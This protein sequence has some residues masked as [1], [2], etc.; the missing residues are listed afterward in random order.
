VGFDNRPYNVATAG[1]NYP[2]NMSRWT[3]SVWN[4]VSYNELSNTMAL[5][6][7]SSTATNSDVSLNI[8]DSGGNTFLSFLHQQFL[9]GSGTAARPTFSSPSNPQTG[10]YVDSGGVA[11]ITV[12]GTNRF[13]I[14]SSLV[15]STLPL[16]VP[17]LTATA[18]VS[19]GAGMQHIRGAVGCTTAAAVGATCTSGA[20]TFAVPFINTSYTLACTLD[21]PTGV[22]VVSSVTKSAGSFTI[23]IASLTA[24][25]ATGNF[26]CIGMHD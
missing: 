11:Q 24:V 21:S 6:P 26:N 25:A 17:A 7:V 8:V 16:T 23:T 9:G 5:V 13:S 14:S 18:S 1:A 20:I 12:N 22:P 2:S 3:A 19:S 10:F 15:A 4:G